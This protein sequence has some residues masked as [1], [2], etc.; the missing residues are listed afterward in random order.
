MRRLVEASIAPQ[1]HHDVAGTCGRDDHCLC[2]TCW[3][4]RKNRQQRDQAGLAVKAQP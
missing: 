3:V 2:D 4:R 1:Q